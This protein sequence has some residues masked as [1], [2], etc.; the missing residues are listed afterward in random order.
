MKKP[1]RML[2]F[3]GN[4]GD[5][6]VARTR[7]LS[8]RSGTF[9]VLWWKRAGISRKPWGLRDHILIFTAPWIQ[10]LCACEPCSTT[11][12]IKA[13]RIWHPHA[14]KSVFLWILLKK[15]SLEILILDF[16]VLEQWPMFLFSIEWPSWPGCRLNWVHTKTRQPQ[17]THQLKV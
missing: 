14:T 16:V 1:I 2:D 17:V 15:Q 11:T 5:Q 6:T 13:W 9:A 3:P 12:K 10:L 4:Q 8:A 7:F